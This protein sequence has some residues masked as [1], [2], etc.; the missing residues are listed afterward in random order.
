MQLFGTVLRTL[1]GGRDRPIAYFISETTKCTWIK[2]YLGILG[3]KFCFDP[4][5]V[6][7]TR[8]LHD[9]Y[10]GLVNYLKKKY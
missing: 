3:T 10:T 5:E 1:L 9:A 4:F 6:S 2:I 8:A 7:V